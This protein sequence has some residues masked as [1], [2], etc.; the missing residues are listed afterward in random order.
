MPRSTSTQA[1]RRQP[2]SPTSKAGAL[3]LWKGF[4][5]GVAATVAMSAL[6][7]VGMAT[8]AAPMP[9]PVPAALVA[10]VF[11]A[12]LA[13]PLVMVLAVG[14]H[15]AYGGFFGAVLAWWTPHVT[16][17]KGLGLG[18]LL[19]LL[20]QVAVL[21]FLGWGLFGTAVTP[22]I[23]GATLVLHLVYGLVLGWSLDR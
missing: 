14:S 17:G 19:W 2:S 13:Q 9:E 23:A 8:G 7:I 4:G 20:M 21:P 11:G 12:G 6:M 16:V 10:A 5:W 22:K 15:L 1:T 3:R 18:A